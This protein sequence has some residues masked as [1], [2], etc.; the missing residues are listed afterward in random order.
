MAGA[1][2]A[3]D[4]PQLPGW[5]AGAFVDIEAAER[6]LSADRARFIKR[7]DIMSLIPIHVQKRL[8]HPG[9]IAQIEGFHQLFTLLNA[10]PDTAELRELV[11]DYFVMDPTL[12]VHLRS[13]L[14]HSHNRHTIPLPADPAESSHTG[15][16][17]GEY[18]SQSRAYLTYDFPLL[19]PPGWTA[20]VFVSI[21]DAEVD[22]CGD[23]DNFVQRQDIMLLIPR[24]IRMLILHP[25]DIARIKGI[26]EL[27]T[28]LNINSD[29]QHIRL[30]MVDYFE[31]TP[32]LRGH[33]RS[34]SQA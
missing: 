14:P 8:F 12:R 1:R 5:T 29:T 17:L 24:D 28:F 7:N 3:Q 19:N 20:G 32:Y 4:A 2:P 22:L 26:S 13:P 23:I 31:N 18:T 34:R 21:H 27:F 10:A 6:H 30:L 9:D 16:S 25:G 11:V 33:L 15:A